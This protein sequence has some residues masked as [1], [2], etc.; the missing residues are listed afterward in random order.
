LNGFPRAF[1]QA[2]TISQN[3][4]PIYQAQWPLIPPPSPTVTIDGSG[5]PVTIL[6]SGPTVNP[7]T[8]PEQIGV[9]TSIHIHFNN[10]MKTTVLPTVGLIFS[11]GN[12]LTLTG[13]SW[14]DQQTFNIREPLKIHCKEAVESVQGRSRA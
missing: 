8:S 12:I 14:G 3:Q 7:N 5:L 2:V 10:P 1:V 9:G 13:G 11:D 6:A 4:T